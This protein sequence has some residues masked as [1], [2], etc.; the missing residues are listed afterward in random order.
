MYSD[1]DLYNGGD[2]DTGVGTIPEGISSYR[3]SHWVT[4]LIE[5]MSG[6]SGIEAAR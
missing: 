2:S 5:S 6:G 3:G 1:G 4:D